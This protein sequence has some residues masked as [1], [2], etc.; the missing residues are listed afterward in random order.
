MNRHASLGAPLRNAIVANMLIVGFSSATGGMSADLLQLFASDVLGLSSAQ[1]GL[2]LSLL[3]V[4][5]PL[6]LSAPGLVRRLGYRRLMQVGYAMCLP[7]LALLAVLPEIGDDRARFVA[8]CVAVVSIECVISCSWGSAWHA[9]MRVVVDREQR[10]RFLA[11]M[12]G[13]AQAFNLVLTT[14]FALAV[15]AMVSAEEY[16]ALIVVLAAALV[17]SILLLATVPSPP[18]PPARP[19]R[20]PSV[21]VATRASLRDGRMRGMYVLT[22]LELLLLVPVMPIFLTTALGLGASVVAAQ[23]SLRAVVAIIVTPVWG[24]VQ[25]ARG[26]AGAARSALSFFVAGAIVQAAMVA[27]ASTVG[28]GPSTY[29]LLVV[30]TV[31]SG[32][33]SAGYGNAVMGLWY[34]AVPDEHAVELFTVQDIL[35]SARSQLGFLLFGVLLSVLGPH[36]LAVGDVRFHTFGFVLL[37][38]AVVALVA[39]WTVARHVGDEMAPDLAAG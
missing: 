24:R 9:W 27:T 31:I 4:S 38:G 12:R 1:I 20:M 14:G 5:V 25:Q 7:L 28:A 39:R 37:A 22:F 18:A 29:V 19:G 6:Q 35:G 33:A 11:S 17:V 13:A 16:R 3:L 10:P 30:S 36:V 8:F 32:V 34:E 23:I 15:G 21:L 2:A 26:A